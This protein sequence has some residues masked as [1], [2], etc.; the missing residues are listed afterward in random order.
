MTRKMLCSLVLIIL[1]SLVNSGCDT[2][3]SYAEY[4]NYAHYEDSLNLSAIE[5]EMENHSIITSDENG[6]GF[7]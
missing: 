5:A 1:F 2:V 4:Y 7:S 3:R 6:G